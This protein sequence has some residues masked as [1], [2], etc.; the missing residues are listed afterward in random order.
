MTQGGEVGGKGERERE[1]Q[2]CGH[3]LAAREPE[4]WAI[5]NKGKKMQ[6]VN[7]NN[8]LRG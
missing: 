8:N 4:M 3:I 1:E 7:D 5:N 6:K 2:E